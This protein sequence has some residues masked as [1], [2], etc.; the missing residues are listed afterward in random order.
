MHRPLQP[1]TGGRNAR[2]TQLCDSCQRVQEHEALA[3]NP[4]LVRYVCREHKPRFKGLMTRLWVVYG[5]F[6]DPGGHFVRLKS[7]K[8]GL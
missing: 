7:P 5:H 6:G 8:H 4:D 1:D 3:N 2:Q